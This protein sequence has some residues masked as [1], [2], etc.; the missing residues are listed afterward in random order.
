MK[1]YFI[2]F[3]DD[4]GTTAYCQREEATN[5]LKRMLD[6]LR[7]EERVTIIGPG[8][9]VTITAK[10]VSKQDFKTMQEQSAA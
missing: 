3:D 6:R 7:V 5:M 1:V 4:A 9:K 2:E 10:E 8:D